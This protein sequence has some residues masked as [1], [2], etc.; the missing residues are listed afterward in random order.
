M[1]NIC[2]FAQ[3][4]APRFQA[5][6]AGLFVVLPRQ[7]ASEPRGRTMETLQ[8]RVGALFGQG[9]GRHLQ[10]LHRDERGTIAVV[11]AITF[12]GMMLMAA[13]AI[14]FGRTQ[15]EVVRVQNAVDTA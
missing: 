10:S 6:S 12:A 9:L 1:Q 11:F 13:I 7:M 3:N 15:T 14:D 2:K 8:A 5:A 4:W